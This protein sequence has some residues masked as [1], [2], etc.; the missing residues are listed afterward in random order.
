[1][2]NIF[3]DGTRQPKRSGIVAALIVLLFISISCY[4][5]SR[6]VFIAYAEYGPLEKTLAVI[7]F[8]AEAFVMLHA[9]GYFGEI[10]RTNQSRR[11][12]ITPQPLEEYPRVA[13]LIPARHEPQTVLL[14]TLTGCYNLDY[15]NKRI[16]LLDD[17]SLEA[18]SREAEDAAARFGATVFRRKERHGAKAGIINDCLKTLEDKYVAIFDADQVPL[19]HFLSRLV[20]LLEADDR[21]A[22]IQ[23]PQFY[24]NLAASRVSRAA[25]MQQAIF[26]EYVC[27]GKNTSQAMIC[28]GTN[29]VMRR[30]ALSDV[31]GFDESTVT[32]DFA[33][34]LELH[35]KHWKTLYTNR[36]YVFGLG[37]ENLSGYFGQQNRWA[38]G[39]VMVLRTIIAKLMRQ[40]FLLKPSQWFEYAVTG[41][42][43]FIGWTYL[44]LLI[45]PIIY[46]FFNIPSFFMN[47]TVYSFAFLPY[48]VLSLAIFY[49]SMGAR[50]Y[51]IKQVFQ[52]QLL[53]FITLPV[54]LRASIFGLA[55]IKAKFQVTAKKGTKT[56]S[57][58]FLWPQLAFWAINLIAIT[59][60]LNRLMYE[61][62]A[63]V[64][65]NLMWIVYHFLILSSIF[66]FNEE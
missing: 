54:Y 19:P 38:L 41:S 32:E 43:Y 30:E 12:I 33:T 52:G 14:E 62:T 31:G 40:P 11:R 64:T 4:F 59:W 42:Y 17:S 50:H 39:N 27:E 2:K 15:P 16:Y 66:Y 21:L 9:F 56:I 28:C 35:L 5:V 63:A 47:P 46:I 8:I 6:A 18:Y 13:I 55:G 44:F 45:C 61:R 29:V 51:N 58:W 26:Y 7:F 20:P 10:L 60:G 23:T 1:M 22:F 48:L 65:I 53:G 37:P 49:S 34:S 36:V 24:S 57:Y 25:D 3:A